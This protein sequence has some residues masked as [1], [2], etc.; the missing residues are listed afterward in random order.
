MP[1]FRKRTWR[2]AGRTKRLYLIPCKKNMECDGKVSRGKCEEG[3]TRLVNPHPDAVPDD[4]GGLLDIPLHLLHAELR[5]RQDASYKPA[6]GSRTE[7]TY[8][9]TG[10]HVFALFLI[11]GLST[12]GSLR[13]FAG[14]FLL[15]IQCHQRAHSPSLLGDFLASRFPIDFSSSPGILGPVSSLRPPSYIFC[16]RRS[17]R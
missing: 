9:N 12:L 1:S 2:L 15:L 16:P 13:F 6:C 8:Y 4:K 5:R 10:S 14:I 7:G 3:P 11:L 17:Y